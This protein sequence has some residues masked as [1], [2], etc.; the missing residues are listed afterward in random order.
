[1]IVMIP[2]P[3]IVAVGRGVRGLPRN[4]AVLT[5]IPVPIIGTGTVPSGWGRRWRRMATVG[6]AAASFII[7]ELVL[8]A[9]VLLVGV[10]CNEREDRR[11]CEKRESD[12]ETSD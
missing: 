3:I 5:G 8:L 7:P 4:A 12:G 6:K 9:A 10:G 1:L 11:R 2:M